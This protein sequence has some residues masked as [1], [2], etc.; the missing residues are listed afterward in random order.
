MT[1]R[2][3]IA[4]IKRM[5][6]YACETRTKKNYNENRKIVVKFKLDGC[7]CILS[8]STKSIEMKALSTVDWQNENEKGSEHMHGSEGER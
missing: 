2:L 1:H 5:H 6:F 3:C 4:H 8:K 7:P